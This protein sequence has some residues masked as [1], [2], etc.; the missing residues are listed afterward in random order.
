MTPEHKARTAVR[1]RGQE[2][3]PMRTKST[4]VKVFVSDSMPLSNVQV[5]K[6][7]ISKKQNET[8]HISRNVL[9]GGA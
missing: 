3:H 7:K 2:P 1:G 4:V 5:Q 8:P 9:V 6:E